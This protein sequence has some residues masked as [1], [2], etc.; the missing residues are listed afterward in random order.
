MKTQIFS[1]GRVLGLGIAAASAGLMG[2][3]VNAVHATAYSGTNAIN[4]MFAFSG[5]GAYTTNNS[6]VGGYAAVGVDPSNTGTVWNQ[7]VPTGNFTVNNA[8]TNGVPLPKGSAGG[9]SYGYATTTNILSNLS[10]SQGNATDV[11]VT[12]PTS[13]ASTSWE[14]AVWATNSL[15]TGTWAY[16][17]SGTAGAPPA[18]L[19]IE[20]S[21][22][23][24]SSQYNLYL[25]GANPGTL[26]VGTTFSLAAT[27]VV[28]GD[29]AAASTTGVS[30][31][32]DPGK[33]QPFVLPWNVPTTAY[34][35]GWASASATN[36]QVW[37]MLQAQA[38]ST[39]NITFYH[40]NIAGAIK[41]AVNGFQLQPVANVA[42]PEP[43][44]V[45]LFGIAAGAGLLLT[46]RRKRI[47]KL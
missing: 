44:T 30:A 9:D 4:F 2:T 13:P 29:A 32:S 20:I 21:G 1:N 3:S 43:T 47:A 36:G 24:P 11:T 34:G 42:T 16:S 41:D 22:L 6:A 17:Y 23:T 5:E 38:D 28:A 25:Y 8:T 7:M 35:Y 39:G 10:D 14:S 40:A 46:S 12:I 19:P 37:T 27:N 15:L 33:N 18:A 45:A 26:G 31:A